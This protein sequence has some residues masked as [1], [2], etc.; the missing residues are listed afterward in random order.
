MID[1]GYNKRRRFVDMVERQ[2]LTISKACQLSGISRTYGYKILNR[3]YKEGDSGLESK[4][5]IMI[6]SPRKIS[7]RTIRKV[8]CMA[9]N[10]PS[11]GPKWLQNKLLDEGIKVSEGKIY[12]ILKDYKISKKEERLDILFNRYQKGRKIDEI[13]LEE[14]EKLSH[15]FAARDYLN[16]KLGSLVFMWNEW[17]AVSHITRKTRFFIFLDLCGSVVIIIPELNYFSLTRSTFPSDFSKISNALQ[18]STHAYAQPIKEALDKFYRHFGIEIDTIILPGNDK[19]I[20]ILRENISKITSAKLDLVDTG[21]FF[22]FPL[23]EAFSKY[24]KREFL[25]KRLKE[26]IHRRINKETGQNIDRCLQDFLIHY[27]QERP[28]SEWPNLGLSPYGYASEKHKRKIYLPTL[29]ENLNLV[30]S[31]RKDEDKP[32]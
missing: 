13:T 15:S 9:I 14:M 10:Y 16:K 17:G 7:E 21:D 1:K 12:S 5:P 23:I 3:Y 31:R 28:I 8:V 19:G 4:K 20:P 30:R 6:T 11:R 29:K 25:K 27:N 2:G 26:V 32:Q 18:N 24:F 22:S